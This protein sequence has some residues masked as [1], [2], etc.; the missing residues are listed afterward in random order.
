M[1][2]EIFLKQ[3]LWVYFHA[4]ASARTAPKETLLASSVRLKDNE[5]SWNARGVRLLLNNFLQF[6]NYAINLVV[7]YISAL[8]LSL[9]ILSEV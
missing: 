2:L 5:K 7:F 4:L 9:N 8:C 6:S 1:G 3:M